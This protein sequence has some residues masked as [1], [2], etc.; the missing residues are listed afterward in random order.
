MAKRLTYARLARTRAGSSG[1]TRTDYRL[2]ITIQSRQSYLAGFGE[3]T[4]YRRDEASEQDYA[5]RLGS[6]WQV[7]GVIARIMS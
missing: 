4:Q 3:A 7:M 1:A 5:W 6:S 2:K